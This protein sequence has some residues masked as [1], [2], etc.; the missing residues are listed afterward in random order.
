[1]AVD[2]HKHIIESFNQEWTLSDNI[3]EQIYA[4]ETPEPQ[5]EANATTSKPDAN[6]TKPKST[7]KNPT[8][9][10]QVSA[11]DTRRMLSSRA[12]RESLTPNI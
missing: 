6:T 2:V 3:E 1:M 12:G 4:D 5:I 8:R 10:S 11:G 7:N 9:A